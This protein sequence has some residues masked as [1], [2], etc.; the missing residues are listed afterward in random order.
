MLFTLIVKSLYLYGWIFLSL[1]CAVYK[2]RFNY[3]PFNHLLES[4]TT[5]WLETI[6]PQE[7]FIII[8]VSQTSFSHISTNSS[9]ISTVSKLA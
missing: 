2:D 3:L 5:T 8:Y 4:F 6:I 9:T 1:A 7:N